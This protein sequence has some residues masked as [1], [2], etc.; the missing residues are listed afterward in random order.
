MSTILSWTN[1]SVQG[2]ENHHPYVII[3]YDYEFPVISENEN[4][5]EII[6]GVNSSM[7]YSFNKHHQH[8]TLN[9]KQTWNTFHYSVGGNWTSASGY[10]S[11]LCVGDIRLSGIMER[12]MSGRDSRREPPQTATTSAYMKPAFINTLNFIFPPAWLL[13]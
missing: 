11:G 1:A 2:S 13:T 6:Q 9:R 3:H 7:D 8:C 10:T 4:L 5:N 12:W